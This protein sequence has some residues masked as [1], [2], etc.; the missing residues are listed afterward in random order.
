MHDDASTV[1]ERIRVARLLPSR[2]SLVVSCCSLQQRAPL[3]RAPLRSSA[4]LLLTWHVNA[5]QALMSGDMG[6]TLAEMGASL[7]GDSDAEE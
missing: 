2:P 7:K 5:F 1:G 6:K 3:G 4:V